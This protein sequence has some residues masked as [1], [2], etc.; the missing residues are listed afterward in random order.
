MTAASS[1]KASGAACR[2]QSEKTVREPSPDDEFL[3]LD[4]EVDEFAEGFLPGLAEEYSDD[5]DDDEDEEND[6]ESYENG[7]SGEEGN[8]RWEPD[9]WDENEDTVS[10]SGS[11]DGHDESAEL[12]SLPNILPGK[13]SLTVSI[14]E[15]TPK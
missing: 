1:S 10:E 6:R 4:S 13:L 12:V 15:K 2:K 9:N 3:E 11:D 14:L 8:A 5:D 7:E